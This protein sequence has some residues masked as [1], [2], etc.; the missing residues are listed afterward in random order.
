[1]SVLHRATSLI[2]AL[3]LNTLAVACIGEALQ[4]ELLGAFFAVCFAAVSLPLW[5]EVLRGGWDK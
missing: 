3:A 5:R 1:M 2:L 4:G